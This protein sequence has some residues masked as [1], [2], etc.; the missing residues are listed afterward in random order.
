MINLDQ[1]LDLTRFVVVDIESTG[2]T[3]GQHAIIEVGMVVLEGG[4]IVARYSSLVNPH[5]VIPEF[6]SA[7]TGITNEMVADAPEEDEVIAAIADELNH[8]HAVFVAHNVGFDWSFISKAIHNS[9]RLVP[10][11]VR[12]CTCK[13]SRRL[14]TELKRHDLSS[15]AVHCGID[16]V[17]RHR[18]LGDA[19][20]TVEALKEMLRV[21]Q[22]DHAAQTLG[23]LVA[24]QY[25]PRIRSRR[26]TV[27]AE[28]LVD[29]LT[30]VPE[31][32]GVYYFYT[33]KKKLLYVGKA[34]NLAKRVRS[35]FHDAPLHGRS[36]SKM[37]RYIKHIEWTPTGTELGALLL[38]SQEI[39]EKQPSH[40]VMGK[41][42]IAPWFITLSNDAFPRIDVAD[43]VS[44]PSLDYYGPFRSQL[45][46][47][48]VCEMIRAATGLRRCNGVLEPNSSFRP[49]FDYHV[50]KCPGPCAELE[51][52]SAYR[53]RVELAR[54]Y[55]GSGMQSVMHSLHARMEQ[56]ANDHAFELAALYRDGIRE[57]ERMH[58][59]GASMPLSVRDL[60]VVI[61]VAPIWSQT[62]VDI[63][64]LR[65]GRL[66]MQ[67]TV[68]V[69]STLDSVAERLFTV[70]SQEVSTTLSMM[71][72]DQLRIITSW[73]HQHK[74]RTS[75][76][77]VRD[78]SA[79]AIATDLHHAIHGI[80]Q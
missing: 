53:E 36:V 62:S 1:P 51:S 37:V 30:N 38:E 78:S 4:L 19:E 17:G 67:A 66:R 35:Y 28:A 25:A 79:S 21:A 29:Y 56:A 72:L 20:A 32:P 57:V 14:F 44:D 27:A 74:E 41:D 70:Y 65:S 71:E 34:L 18:A 5:D 26:E 43:N 7:M 42:Y 48:R 63:F 55:L 80:V 39:K 10:E 11:L 68:G 12:L 16:I 9:G 2:G 58:V 22:S 40:N 8:P 47:I 45:I 69:E 61:V 50:E 75:R 64:A 23:E 54:A 13:L 24:L 76:F 31:E 60:N 59:Y 15:V 49:C 33:A 73:L 3:N 52:A 46:A 77:V 6:I